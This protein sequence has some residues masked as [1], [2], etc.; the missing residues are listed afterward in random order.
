MK[1]VKLKKVIVK[2]GESLDET[3]LW[4]ILMKITDD[5]CNFLGDYEIQWQIKKKK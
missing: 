3:E 2:N 4:K 1:Y 5:Y